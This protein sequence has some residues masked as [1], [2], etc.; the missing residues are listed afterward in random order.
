MTDLIIATPRPLIFHTENL[1]LNPSHYPF[2]ARLGGAS[3]IT[4]IQE[5]YGAGAW[6]IPLVKLAGMASLKPH[7]LQEFN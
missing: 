6:Y 3:W 1:K 7:L 2:H 5:G 4:K